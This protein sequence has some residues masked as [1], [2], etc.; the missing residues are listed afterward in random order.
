MRHQSEDKANWA[1]ARSQSGL[2]EPRDCE[3]L[4][5]LRGF[6]GPILETAPS[7]Q[8]LATQLST[9]GYGLAFREGHLVILDE[10][11]NGLCTGSSLGIPLRELSAR[12]GRPA[13]RASV[14]GHT[15]EL[16]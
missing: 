6:L 10:A 11:G 16:H 13:V 12:I 5:L 3:T 2:P 9:K 1:N 8:D 7:W 14:D 15:G 4:F